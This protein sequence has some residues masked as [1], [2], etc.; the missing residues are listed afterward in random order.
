[1]NTPFKLC[2]LSSLIAA[3]LSTSALAQQAPKAEQDD[4]ERIVVTATGF[5][6]KVPDAPASISVITAEDIQGQSYTTLLD[7]VKY[8]EGVDVGTTRDKT[9]QGSVSMR[10]LTGEYTLLLI[11][12]KRQKMLL[13]F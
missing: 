13:E 10:G 4:M 6:Q 3:T 9:G 11:D 5:E 2:A 1:M 8:Q 12:G 7:A